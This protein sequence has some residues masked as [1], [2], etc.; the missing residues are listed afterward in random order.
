M[1][2]YLVTD[3]NLCLGR[4]LVKVVEAAVKGGVTMVQLR[5]KAESSRKFLY[6]AQ[7]LKE[8]LSV[9]QVPLIINDRLDIALAAK[10]DGVHVGQDDLPVEAVRQLM[11]HAIIGLSVE[12]FAQLEQA[13]GLPV[14]YI[15][16]S[17]VFTTPTKAELENA[18]GIDGL[19][20]VRSR[21]NLPLVAIGGINPSNAVEVIT[22]G[23]DSLAIVSAI[24]SAEDPEQASRELL[25]LI[26]STQRKS[27]EAN[28]KF[29]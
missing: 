13:A 25:S 9:Y 18:W 24:C 1:E 22:A 5:E 17:P 21:T 7:Q 2:L 16:I 15:G 28:R 4:S 29:K 23:A 27:G 3:E 26:H 19:K 12:N 10:A 20:A 8:I 11:P 14:D 6:K